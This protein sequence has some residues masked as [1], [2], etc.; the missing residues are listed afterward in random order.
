[1]KRPFGILLLCLLTHSSFSQLIIDWSSDYEL[2]LADFQSPQTEINAEMTSYSIIG[3]PSMTFDFQM[4]SYEYMFTKNFNSKV[5]CTFDRGAAI[6]NAPDSLLAQQLV[7]FSQFSFDLC[8]L[9]SRKFR[10]ELYDKKGVF[11]NFSFFQPIFDQLQRELNE[12]NSRV[13][14][15]TNF[16]EDMG[17]LKL[18][19]DQVIRQMELLADFCKDCKPPK[20]KKK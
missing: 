13:L 2:T 8:E 11:S 4:S 9:Y 10:S 5:N 15:A 17:I 16:G 3:G 12:E 1:M 7:N 6:I 14:K 20:R 18:E 19:H